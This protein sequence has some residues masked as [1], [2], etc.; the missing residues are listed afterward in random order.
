MNITDVDIN[1]AEKTLLP[2]D[3]HFD[4]ERR[5]FIKGLE[6]CDLLAVPGSGKTTALQAKLFCMARHLPLEKSQGILVLSHTNNAVNEVKKKL[7]DECSPL[8]EEPHFIGTVQDFVDKFLAIPFYEQFYKQKVHVIDGMAYEQEVEKYLKT[9]IWK[10]TKG[11]QYLYIKGVN[12]TD[13][14]IQRTKDGSLKYTRGMNDELS[15]KP[16]MKWIREGTEQQKHEE[17]KADLKKMKQTIMKKGILHYDD[18]YILADAYIRKYPFVKK[19]LCK[20]FKY[21]FIDETQ[22]LKKYQL[23]LIDS[24]FDSDECCIQRIGDKNQTI[25]NKPDRDIPDQW[26]IRKVKYLQN[27]LRLTESIAKVVNPFAVDNVAGNNSESMFTVKGKR[28]LENGDI[29][30]YLILFDE[31]G[32]NKLLTTFN[33]LIEKYELRSTVDGKKYGFHIIGWSIRRKNGMSNNKLRLEDI[34]PNCAKASEKGQSSYDTLSEFLVFGCREHSMYECKTVIQ[35]ALV[36]LLRKLN[37]YDSDRKFFSKTR[38]ENKIMLIGEDD[39]NDYKLLIY[40]TSVL[41]FLKRFSECYTLLVSY[42]TGSF[43]RIFEISTNNQELAV[44]CEKD[45]D[46]ELINAETPS[47]FPDIEIESVHSTKGQTHCATMYV[48]TSFKDYESSHLFKIKKKATKKSPELFY[49]NP[50][51]QEKAV[52]AQVTCKAVM[53]MMYVGFSRPTHLLCYASYKHNWNDKRIEKM[54]QLGWK[55]INL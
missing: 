27:S 4:D 47:D 54:E 28:Q 1:E 43:S 20:R 37:V 53:H 40:Q 15:F 42:L 18:C 19:T 16:V 11:T 2:K 52:Y 10:L 3:I 33:D 14:R 9:S 31:Y 46:T 35:K 36:C 29:P 30:P 13:I 48:E 50:L 32:K 49:P 8:F 38:L 41:L 55:I 23:D 22:D 34:F 45:F 44:F 21:V 24:I 17:I 39:F 25:F 5:D 51:F 12:F 6:S 26:N 7:Y